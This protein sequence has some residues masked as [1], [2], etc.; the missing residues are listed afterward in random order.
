[1][2]I[3]YALGLA[4]GLVV[5]AWLVWRMAGWPCPSRL[6]WLLDNPFTRD[7]YAKVV[8]LLGPAEGL[9]VLDAGCGPGRLTAP[10]AQAVGPR[11]RV[12]AVDIQEPMILRAK[13]RV[14]E[15]GLTNVEFLCAA[16]GAGALPEE[17]FDRALM[18]TVLGEIPD[19]PAALREVYR[20]LRPGGSLSVTEVLP[21]PHYISF[22]RLQ[23]LAVPVGFQVASR[24][25]TWLAYT[26]SLVRPRAERGVI[27]QQ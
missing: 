24:Q 12:F 17:E 19:R 6:A 9:A 4:A 7:Y 16:L 1:M 20:S 14:A 13:R 8:S 2:P 10:I 5:I 22:G 11:G 26:A 27:S 25:G 15:A 3:L 23:R 21:D 18:V